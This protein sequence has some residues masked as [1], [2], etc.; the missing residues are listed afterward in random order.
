MDR[1]SLLPKARP[2]SRRPLQGAF[3]ST[4]G[5]QRLLDLC[6]V[7]LFLLLLPYACS[8]LSEKAMW[9]KKLWRYPGTKAVSW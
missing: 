2:A 6:A 1:N 9:E 8:L 4:A 7:L 3:R 5:R